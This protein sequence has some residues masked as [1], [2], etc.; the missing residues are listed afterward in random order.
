VA[1]PAQAAAPAPVVVV[2]TVEATLM[3]AIGDMQVYTGRGWTRLAP[4]GSVPVDPE[5]VG[6]PPAMPKPMKWDPVAHGEPDPEP[7]EHGG[8]DDPVISELLEVLLCPN[9]DMELSAAACTPQH[10]YLADN[11]VEHR[12]LKPLLVPYLKQLRFDEGRL[13]RT[14]STEGG[15][16]VVIAT[17]GCKHAE[18]RGDQVLVSRELW[19]ALVDEIVGGDGALAGF[20]ARLRDSEEDLGALLTWHYYHRDDAPHLSVSKYW[21]EVAAA[22]LTKL[23]DVFEEKT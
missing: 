1:P 8:V 3:P 10:A 23:I 12:L 7:D 19:E 20:M 9:C 21:R 18:V 14:C 6:W 16:D 2:A 17:G 13:C 22:A 11:P 4:G 15:P 5:T